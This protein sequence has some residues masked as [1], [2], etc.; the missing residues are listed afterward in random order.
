MGL[1][2]RQGLGRFVGC[3]GRS[4]SDCWRPGEVTRDHA[5]Q[6]GMP[7]RQSQ[8]LMYRGERVTPGGRVHLHGTR[9]SPEGL[10]GYGWRPRRIGSENR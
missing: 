5:W 6:S 8:V 3:P 9:S 7:R 2:N 10:A 1:G 4:P